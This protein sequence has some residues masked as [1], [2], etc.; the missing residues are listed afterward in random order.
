VETVSFPWRELLNTD[1]PLRGTHWN[2]FRRMAGEPSFVKD[3]VWTWEFTDFTDLAF[4]G[5]DHPVEHAMVQLWIED[6]R[7]AHAFILLE[8][9]DG[10]DHEE[11]LF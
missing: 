7:V 3:G 4:G 11:V 8:F 5:E 10:T 2:K 9:T 1:Q 6:Q